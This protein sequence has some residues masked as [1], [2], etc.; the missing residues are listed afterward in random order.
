MKIHA[1]PDSA[2]CFAN[3]PA[4]E[5]GDAWSCQ[6]CA[7]YVDP[8]DPRIFPVDALRAFVIATPPPRESCCGVHRAPRA[9]AEVLAALGEERKLGGEPVERGGKSVERV[10]EAL[11]RGGGALRQLARRVAERKAQLADCRA[12]A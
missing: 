5:S 6:P 4:M 9:V 12:N 3:S 1:R 11:A 8:A 10:D 7:R 2:T